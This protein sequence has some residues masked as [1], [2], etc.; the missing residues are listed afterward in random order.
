MFE[1]DTIRFFKDVEFAGGD[2]VRDIVFEEEYI[3]IPTSVIEFGQDSILD[4]VQDT[5]EQDNIG[6]PVQE[7]VPQEQTLLPQEPMPLRRS[8]RQRK[9]AVPNDYIVFVQEN[10]VDIGMVEDNPINFC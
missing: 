2:T 3:D 7:A 4:L 9:S 5:I 10:E 6:D 8:T 1:S